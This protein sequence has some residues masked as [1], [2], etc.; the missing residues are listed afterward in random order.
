[1][2][3]VKYRHTDMQRLFPLLALS[4]L[5]ATAQAA[6][7]DQAFAEAVRKFLPPAATAMPARQPELSF[8]PDAPRAADSSPTAHPEAYARFLGHLDQ[9]LKDN[10]YDFCLAMKEILEATNDEFAVMSWMEKA[11][12]DGNPAACQ[13]VGDR[14]LTRVARNETQSPEVKAAYEMVRKAADAGYDAAKINVY[15]CMKA[16]IGT[17][18]ND[19]AAE[20]YLIEA[21]RSGN[22][23]PRYKWLQMTGRLRDWSDRERPEVKAEIDRGNHHV[24]YFLSNTAPS[25]ADQIAMLRQAAEKGNPEALYTLSALSSRNAPRD[26]YTLLQE[27]VRLHSADALFAMGSAMTDGDPDNPVLKEAGVQH[28]DAAGRAFIKLSAMLGNVSACFWLGSVNY[29]GKCGFSVDQERAFLHF[30]HGALAGNATCGTAAGLMLLRGL[31]TTQDTHKGL[32]YLNVAANAGVPHAV[33]LLAYAQHMGL[34][35]PADSAAAFKLLQ[36]AAAMGQKR[37]Y[38]YMAYITAKGGNN[39]PADPRMAERYVRMAALD[40]KEE[41]R[42]TYDKLMTEGWNP[43]P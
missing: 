3:S 10:T 39:M 2:L 14:R 22:M 32:Y 4:V 26:S 30:N 38:V 31:G 8:T 16:G 7:D 11:A 18:Q 17:G 24:I 34:G 23:I 6:A 37:A 1:M 28:N 33:I 20:A 36:E 43:E 19:E 40:L 29:H 13:F 5:P 15:M 25:A 42:T 41:A 27:A 35:M 9:Q 12:A 21:C